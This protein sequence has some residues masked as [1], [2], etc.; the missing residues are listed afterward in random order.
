MSLLILHSFTPVIKTIEI[1]IGNKKN[2][3][4]TLNILEVVACTLTM[5]LAIYQSIIFLRCFNFLI[6]KKMSSELIKAS[7]IK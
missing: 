3:N 5:S 2:N 4:I 1:I 6:K 7:F